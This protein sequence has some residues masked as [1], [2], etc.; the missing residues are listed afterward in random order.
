[1]QRRTIHKRQR[2][3]HRIASDERCLREILFER[4]GS[5]LARIAAEMEEVRS[6]GIDETDTCMIGYEEFLRHYNDPGSQ[7]IDFIAQIAT[8]HP[9]YFGENIE[10][11]PTGDFQIIDRDDCGGCNILYATIEQLAAATGARGQGRALPDVSYI[12][13]PEL[14]AARCQKQSDKL[15]KQLDIYRGYTLEYQSYI[16]RGANP[17]PTKTMLIEEVLELVNGAKAEPES[18][19]PYANGRP[20]LNFLNISGESISSGF[21]VSRAVDVLE[22]TL[23]KDLSTEVHRRNDPLRSIGKQ[24][25]RQTALVDGESCSQFQLLG[26]PGA[27]S[28]WHM[29]VMG[30]TW[31][32]TL[33]GIKAWCIIDRPDDET[34]WKAF[35]DEQ[36]GGVSWRPRQGTVKMVPITPGYTLLMMPGKFTA[37][38]PV[39]AGDS[40]THMIGGQVWP[41]QPFY[42]QGLLRSLLYLLENN[43]TVTNEFA[44][45]QLPDLIDELRLQT[46][47]KTAGSSN[48]RD[49]RSHRELLRKLDDFIQNAKALLACD[50]EDALCKKKPTPVPKKNGTRRGCPCQHP[51]P[52]LQ[53]KVSHNGGCTAWCHGG[54]HLHPATRSCLPVTPGRKRRRTAS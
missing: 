21:A 11:T 29:D 50:C 16:Q 25:V 38:L 20:P 52:Q 13:I 17:T 15:F 47:K 5:H 28:M 53:A 9:S 7:G 37:H 46:F 34:L 1:M 27:I 40:I 36:T 10:A 48:A 22:L 14:D 42:V 45:R 23:L 32:Q 24:T 6:R 8:F 39:S 33:S 4:S 18:C 44:P 35:A 54:R 49:L 31:V 41:T 26:L 30:M 43:A 51:S 19:R 2:T 3:N 12:L